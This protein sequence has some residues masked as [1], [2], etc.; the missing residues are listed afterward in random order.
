MCYR[1][2]DTGVISFVV[3]GV[4]RTHPPLDDLKALVG[5][6]GGNVEHYFA[7]RR[8]THVIAEAISA[9]KVKS[10]LYVHVVER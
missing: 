4:G 8:V 10:L 5:E 3:A 1:A 6:H 2:H 7:A 9:S